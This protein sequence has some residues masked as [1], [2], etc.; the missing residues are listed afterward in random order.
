MRTHLS[1]LDV[2]M[3]SDILSRYISNTSVLRAGDPASCTF[4]SKSNKTVDGV[5]G[6]PFDSTTA[7]V[8]SKKT[9]KVKSLL[10]LNKV[11]VYLL[12][13][14]V[15]TNTSSTVSDLAMS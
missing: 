13:G 1:C 9:G 12:E 6:I 11:A 5:S 10:R 8:E 7:L 2:I 14:P 15:V 3:I 4:L